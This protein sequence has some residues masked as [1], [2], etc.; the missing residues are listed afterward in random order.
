MLI[1][2]F[3]KDLRMALQIGAEVKPNDILVGKYPKGR[4]QLSLKKRLL[5]NLE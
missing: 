4:D 3:P 2:K 5:S 1:E